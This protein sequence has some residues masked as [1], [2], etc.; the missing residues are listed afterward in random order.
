MLLL[1][2]NFQPAP[3]WILSGHY[4]GKLAFEQSNDLDGI[5][6]AHLFAARVT[7]D[8]TRRWDVGL[9]TRMLFS[10]RDSA[11]RF[12]LGPEVGLRLRDRVRIA[13]G[14]NFLGFRD[15]DLSSEEYTD[16][17]IYVALRLMFDESLFG[18]R[19]EARQ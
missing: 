10:S 4:G 9:S 7:Y 1:D 8:L 16:H 3:D 12:G 2:V 13:F 15:R 5:S 17:G 18:L 19:K 11:V 6:D 14:Y